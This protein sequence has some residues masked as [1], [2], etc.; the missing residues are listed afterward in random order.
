MQMQV[1]Y[2][3]GTYSSIPDLDAM[4]ANQTFVVEKIDFQQT[5]ESWVVQ[6]TSGQLHILSN[7]DHFAVRITAELYL[8]TT[9][10]YEVR[11]GKES[12]RTRETR[13]TRKNPSRARGARRLDDLSVHVLILAFFVFISPS[14]LFSLSS[15]CRPMTDPNCT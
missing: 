12:K 11:Q 9:G 5:T 8:P 14:P 7:A 15:S 4:K 1:F 13:E 10:E 3:S 2:Y 6:E